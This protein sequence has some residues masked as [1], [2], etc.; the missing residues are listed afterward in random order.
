MTK[1]AK[2][3]YEGRCGSCKNFA[4]YVKNGDTME[5]GVCC[6]PNRV[7]YHQASQ[8]ACKEYKAE[9]EDN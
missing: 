3:N 6:H 2:G 9:S 4:F 8:K 5:Q 1:N 7:N